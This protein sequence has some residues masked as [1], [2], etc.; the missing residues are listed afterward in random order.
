M[1]TNED[2]LLA[3]D[4]RQNTLFLRRSI[5]PGEVGQAFCD[6]LDITQPPG[7]RPG[8]FQSGGLLGKANRAANSELCVLYTATGTVKN[9]SQLSIS[10]YRRAR[11]L[12]FDQTP[13]Q[14]DGRTDF[15]VSNGRKEVW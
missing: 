3:L 2:Q 12:S 7:T 10:E 14:G 9:D 1:R 11:L 5:R 8:V 13:A 15:G 4:R 6:P